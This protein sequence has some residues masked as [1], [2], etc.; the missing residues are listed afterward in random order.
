MNKEDTII[1]II[2]DNKEGRFIIFSEWNDTFDIIRNLLKSNELDFVEI[3]GSVDTRQRH[4]ENFQKGKVN[5][6]FLN[7]R[8]DSSGINMQ[9]TTDIILYHT[10]EESVRQQIIGRA[11]RIGRKVALKVHQLISV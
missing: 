5:I 7:S 2:K 3:K 11:N 10:M 4:I 6:A 8:T 9:E 1:K